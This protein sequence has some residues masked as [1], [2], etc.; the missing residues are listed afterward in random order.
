MT[1][2]VLVPGMWLG[3]WAWREVARALRDA[4]HDAYPVTLTG[5]AE[6]AHLGGPGTDL[7]THI[8]D[9]TTL[10]E[11]EELAEVVL[12]AHSYAGAPV[13]GAADRLGPR[14]AH[15]VY[16]DSG[17]VPDGVAHIEFNPPEERDRIKSTVRDGWRLPPPPF[18]PDQDPVN[19]AGLSGDHLARMRRLATPHPYPSVTQP[20]RR[21]GKPLPPRTLIACTMP[22]DQ[23]RALVAAGHPFFAG[24]AGA[25][26]LPL[27]TGHWPMFS[28]PAGLA[29]LLAAATG[30]TGT[31]GD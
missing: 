15:V 16:V 30:G 1:T 20:L 11:V 3:G 8:A 28:E 21:T 25:P 24:L 2:F 12:V 19:L 6:R 31:G 7:D 4:G 14:V 26:V 27:P 9:I 10:V 18:D 5:L 29:E 23:V 13:T 22:P 17:P